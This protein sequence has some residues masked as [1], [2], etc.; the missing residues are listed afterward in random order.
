MVTV[1]TNLFSL[2]HKRPKGVAGFRYEG[3][4]DVF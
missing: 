4:V 2:G 1:V 3:S